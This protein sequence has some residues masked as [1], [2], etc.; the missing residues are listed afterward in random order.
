MP[1]SSRCFA[2]LLLA[3]A[4]STALATVSSCQTSSDPKLPSGTS[5]PFGDAGPSIGEVGGDS[6]QGGN[7]AGT[8][9]GTPSADLPT[10]DNL[11]GHFG[12]GDSHGLE[13]AMLELLFAGEPGW[14]V[15]H[16]FLQHCD[17]EREKILA[18]TH[19]RAFVYPLLRVIAREPDVVA[20][21]TIYLLKATRETTASFVRRELYNF[22]PVF[23][24]F[25]K[26]RYV[27]LK[28]AI[29]DDIVYQLEQGGDWIYKISLALPNLRFDPPVESYLPCLLDAERAR[30]HEIAIRMMLRHGERGL[31]TLMKFFDSKTKSPRTISVAVGHVM[32]LEKD[33][34]GSPHVAQLL[35]DEDPVVKRSAYINYFVY[36][37]G[38]ED[39]PLVLKFLNSNVD[40]KF[41]Q[42][43]LGNLRSKNP[44]VMIAVAPRSA[45]ITDEGLRKLVGKYAASALKKRDAKTSGQG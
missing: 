27:E 35:A 7:G 43:F 44:D 37:R 32:K 20:K 10:F 42:I 8:P 29:Q 28:E 4:L 40:V 39:V 2:T 34:K 24:N 13:A 21:F 33:K 15:I 26:G 1:D 41:R 6:S 38:N 25:H 14:E 9:T 5:P 11:M 18:L 12:R 23:L 3:V 16:R 36:P 17:V 22:V 30:D 31:Q 19:E 45:E